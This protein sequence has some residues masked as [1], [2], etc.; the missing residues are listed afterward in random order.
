[1][2]C[3]KDVE[4]RN[5]VGTGNRKGKAFLK[6]KKHGHEDYEKVE[7]AL[8]Q[9]QGYGTWSPHSPGADSSPWHFRL[10]AVEYRACTLSQLWLQ[11]KC[12]G[13]INSLRF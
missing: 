6:Q 1:M 8:R 5:R 11:D 7:G 13:L 10:R 2:N 4:R 9:R 12:P 3:L